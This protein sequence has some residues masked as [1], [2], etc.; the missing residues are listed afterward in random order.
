LELIKEIRRTYVVLFAPSRT[1]RKAQLRRLQQLF[2]Q[3]LP[4]TCEGDA[5]A[6]TLLRLGR[7]YLSKQ[8]VYC[9]LFLPETVQQQTD[10]ERV[11]DIIKSSTMPP[12]GIQIHM[13][14][15]LGSTVLPI[16]QFQDF[17]LLGSRLRALHRYALALPRFVLTDVVTAL[18]NLTMI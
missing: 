4:T 18:H 14:A 13:K 9:R 16:H 1:E 12:W 11:W 17:P 8:D 10:K 3:T 2:P 7:K 6:S 5:E 15:L